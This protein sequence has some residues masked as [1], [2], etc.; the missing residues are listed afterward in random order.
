MY[1]AAPSTYTASP[2][3]QSYQPSTHTASSQ[4]TTSPTDPIRA[5]RNKYGSVFRVVAHTGGPVAPGAQLSQ[6][7]WSIY[8]LLLNDEGS[9]RFNMSTNIATNTRNGIHETRPHPYT[10]SNSAV[11]YFDVP[12]QPGVS[13]DHVDS[14]IRSN[15]LDKYEMTEGGVGCRWW[16]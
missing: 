3:Q 6:N 8:F 9:V 5:Y 15:G 10:K 14:H 7:H 11:R 2:P 1:S 4:Q 12:I 16:M 13:V